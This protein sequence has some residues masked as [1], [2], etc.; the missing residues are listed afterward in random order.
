MYS[1]LL[2][3]NTRIVIFEVPGWCKIPIS[4]LY[5]SELAIV[6]TSMDSWQWMKKQE[7]IPV[8]CVPAAHWPYPGVSFLGGGCTCPG[9][10]CQG[11]WSGG[12]GPGGCTC[13]GVV[14]AGGA[15][16]GGAC[17]GVPA[18]GGLPQTCPPPVNRM[19]D[20][21]KNIT[22]ATTSLRSVMKFGWCSKRNYI[23]VFM[24]IMVIYSNKQL[25]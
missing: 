4:I 21:C 3:R 16:Q 20:M 6:K 1:I 12:C 7:C 10:A 9:C 15:R 2:I 18:R 11:V 13:P 25:I 17:W 23:Y 19:T 8:G 22:L 24:L 14:P 5:L